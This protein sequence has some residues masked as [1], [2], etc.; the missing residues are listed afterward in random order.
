[1]LQYL[2][3]SNYGISGNGYMTRLELARLYCQIQGRDTD[4]NYQAAKA[5]GMKVQTFPDCPNNSLVI[6][7][8]N[9]HVYTMDDYGSETWVYNE[10]MY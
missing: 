9:T 7:V 2:F 6:E 1:M 5:E 3:G 10:K 4:P 8:S